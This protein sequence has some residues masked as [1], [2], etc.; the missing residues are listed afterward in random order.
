MRRGVRHGAKA[1]DRSP[2]RA[3]LSRG[4]GKCQKTRRLLTLK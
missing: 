1:G 2:A 4:S 3:Q